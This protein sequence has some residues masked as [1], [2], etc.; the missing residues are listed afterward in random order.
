MVEK[1]CSQCG[2]FESLMLSKFLFTVAVMKYSDDSNLG[3]KG[4]ILAQGS[5]VQPIRIGKVK[6]KGAV[7]YSWRTESD[8]SLPSSLSPFDS[9]QDVSLWNGT[10]LVVHPS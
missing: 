10:T 7:V 6:T 5:S 9:V 2:W 8:G 3:E 4:F 1:Q